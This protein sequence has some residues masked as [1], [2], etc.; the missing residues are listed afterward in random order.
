M[1]VACLFA[2]A[3]SACTVGL[4]LVEQFDPEV[5]M[6]EI[7]CHT[8][9]P[10]AALA[11]VRSP[12]H[13]AKPVS[14]SGCR[15]PCALG[16]DVLG[17]GL[18]RPEAAKNTLP[19]SA[20]CQEIEVQPTAETQTL[21]LTEVDWADINLTVAAQR[22]LLISIAGGKLQRVYMT[23][24]GPVEVQLDQLAQLEDLRLVGSGNT[25][26]APRVVLTAA[27]DATNISSGDAHGPFHGELAFRALQ[28]A[29]LDL[30]ADVL[31]VESAFIDDASL[32]ADTLELSDV[33]LQRTL[34]ESTHTQATVF[35][36]QDSS[37]D[38]CGDALLIQGRFARTAV[39][40]CDEARVHLYVSN[41]GSS[42]LD[43]PLELSDVNL[44]NVRLGVSEP[45]RIV[46][47]DLRMA[48][49]HLCRNVALLSFGGASTIRCSSCAEEFEDAPP[50]CQV[51][52]V[53]NLLDDNHCPGLDKDSVDEL[54]ECEA[55]VPRKP[56]RV[57]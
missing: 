52:Y 22:P 57:R 7:L 51:Q 15:R 29:N 48:S 10:C 36:A 17:D 24:R 53:K 27:R 3:L 56:Q 28:L 4:P 13:P 32:R 43:G 14:L 26:G 8:P 6:P 38:L 50:A 55:D 1:R 9:P 19:V 11:P 35:E 45:T 41:L 46:G 16:D 21:S 37:L 18:C 47:F 23:L 25:A 5:P 40:A 30:R 31:T 2:L 44:E 33:T 42:S 12:D 20:M 49:D 54:P 34:I 39:T